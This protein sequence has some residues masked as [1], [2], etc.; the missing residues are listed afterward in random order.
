MLD[1]SH[2]NHI[3]IIMDGNRRWATERNLPKMLG[4]T[5]G[6][7]TLRTI[8]KAVRERGISYLT[9]YA[10]STENV[11]ER[12]QD[13]LNH[14]YSLFE[15]LVDY[16]GDFLENNARLRIIGDLTPLP[17]K[18]KNKLLEVVEKTKNNSTMTL[19]LAIN[20][21]GRDE[22]IRAVRK[23][24]SESTAEISETN[25]NDQLDTVG[26]PDVDLVI[27]T[28]GHHRLSNFLLWQAAY[29]ELFFTDTKW[30]AFSVEELDRIIDWFN[31]QQRNR[32]K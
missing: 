6:A 8:A 27:R 1:Q 29:A 20:Y 17:E 24:A 28:G 9:L 30:P 11:R 15:K 14:L 7:K 13:E 32:G 10:L 31:E 16:I 25:F 21:G 5:E 26:I 22:I 23:L 18:T 2:P 4:H 12:S 19:S 3:A